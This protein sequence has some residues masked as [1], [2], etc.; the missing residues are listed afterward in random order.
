MHS[1]KYV[2]FLTRFIETLSRTPSETI[3]YIYKASDSRDTIKNIVEHKKYKID[4]IH[5]NKP[6]VE[7]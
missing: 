2:H 5:L 6:P 1:Q 7:H 3:I 4:E